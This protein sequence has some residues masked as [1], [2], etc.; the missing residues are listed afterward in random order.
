[1]KIE[2]ALDWGVVGVEL[3]I[4]LNQLPYNRDLRRMLRNL[5][6]MV[7][8]LSKAEVEARRIHKLEYTKEKVDE[9]NKA[10]DHFEKLLL[11]AQLMK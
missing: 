2:T 3:T 4:Q 8:E 1:M 11:I 10:I 6:E 7:T 5:D 9:I